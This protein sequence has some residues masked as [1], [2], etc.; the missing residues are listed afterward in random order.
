MG[1]LDGIRHSQTMRRLRRCLEWERFEATRDVFIEDEE[2]HIG[3]CSIPLPL[4]GLMRSASV[5]LKI[6][7]SMENRVGNFLGDYAEDVGSD[8]DAFKQ[9]IVQSIEK[10]SKRLG[11]ERT[12]RAERLLHEDRLM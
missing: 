10:I 9:R 8:P 7:T 12:K 3:T 4:Y 1:P 5:V 2:G 11:A 6:E